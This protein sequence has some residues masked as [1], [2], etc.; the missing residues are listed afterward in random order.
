MR[1]AAATLDDVAP[2][3]AAYVQPPGTWGWSNAGLISGDHES[4][5]VDTLFDLRTTGAMLEQLAPRIEGRPLVVAVNTHGNGDHCYGNQLLPPACRVYATAATAAGIEETPPSTMAALLAADLP[6][7]LS[8][9]LRHAFGAFDFA[10]I[11]VP[12]PDVTFEDSV[13]L[14]VG[15]R[16][17]VLID[18]GP[19]HTAS[20]VV[21]HVPDAGVVFTGD[22]CF[23][24]GTPIVWAGPLSG[25]VEAC[26]RIAALGPTVLVPGHG[27]IR[28]VDVLDETAAYLRHV[29]AEAVPRLLAGVAPLDAAVDL[30]LGE[31]G[32]W[33]DSERIVANV[34]AVARH[35]DPKLRVTGADVLA[36]MAAYWDRH[37]DRR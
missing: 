14:D 36:G 12:P 35:L 28:S 29:E 21:V 11:D 8:S 17:V 32:R 26:D 18:L 16:A 10:G 9:Y 4:L 5:L 1:T 24:G 19:A 2:G 25:W 33:T 27:P 22:L 34:Y 6:E 7:P 15:G 23:A 31:F 37:R 20:D 13:T 30:P 3:V